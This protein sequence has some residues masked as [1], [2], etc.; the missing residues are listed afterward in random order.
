MIMCSK[1]WGRPLGVK[2]SLETKEKISKA[3]RATYLR[4]VEARKD[5]ERIAELKAKGELV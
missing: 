1:S 3:V 2:Q 5:A 4:K